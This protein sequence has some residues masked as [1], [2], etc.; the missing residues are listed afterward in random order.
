M[1]Q[2][3]TRVL[4]T[5]MGLA[6]LT[7]APLRGQAVSTTQDNT[8]YGTTAGEFLLLGAGARGAALGD[9]FSALT[10]DVTALYYNAAGLAEMPHAEAQ[11]ST[12]N[13]V[14]NTHYTW[15]GLGVPFSGGTRAIGLSLGSFGF[16]NQPVYTL[17]DPDGTSGQTYS[18]SETFIGGTYAQN[19]SDRFSAGFTAKL[20]SDKLGSTNASAFAV[21]FGTNFHALIGDRAIRAAFTIQNLGSSLQA[22]GSALDA[23]VNRTPPLGTVDIPQNAQP[24][25][26][27]ASEWGLPVQF[28]VGVSFEAVASGMNRV[29]ILGMFNQPINNK[30]GASLG[31]EYAASNI[32]NSGFSLS[33]R[34]SYTMKPDNNLDPGNAAGFT[35]QYSSGSFTSNGLAAGGGVA[36][37]RG[38]FLLGFDY[39]YKNMGPLGS[40][41]YLSFS[42]G[43]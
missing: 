27:K 1:T 15:V 4:G 34:G 2:R 14:A 19:F 3:L 35:S 28:L 7:V 32:S 33:L 13:Y 16:S 43:W 38:Q 5:L 18:V 25:S 11:V 12:Y 29:N 37:G 23:G 26:L 36:Y 30:P 40:T 9:G 21:D 42:V 6:A 20:I 10:K 41:N 22:S 31:L 39:A 8:G 17:D 24:A